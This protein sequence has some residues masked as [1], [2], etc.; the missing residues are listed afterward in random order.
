MNNKLKRYFLFLVLVIVLVILIVLALLPSKTLQPSTTEAP[1]ANINSNN[2]I[3]N[4]SQIVFILNTDIPS[5]PASMDLYLSQIES[6]LDEAARLAA[7]N[8]FSP[9]STTKWVSDDKNSF[10]NYS[11]TSHSINFVRYQNSNEQNADMSTSLDLAKEF[12]NA[13]GLSEKITIETETPLVLYDNGTH[14]SGDGPVNNVVVFKLEVLIDEY[15]IKY[16][17]SKLSAGEIWVKDNTYV[18][19]LSLYDRIDVTEKVNTVETLT[20]EE[21]RNQILAGQNLELISIQNAGTIDQPDSSIKQ[22]T[23]NTITIEYRY[24]ENT[25]LIH[26]YLR[27]KGQAVTNLSDNAY[28]E[29][30][31]PLEK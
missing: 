21:V 10:I 26:P 13:N 7:G 16:Q 3:T 23:I 1:P 2:Q 19:K 4:P 5:I 31:L 6:N 11:E 9:T 28:V 8:Q 15:P 17:G 25:K 12:L 14:L 20:S 24:S 30:L 18:S 22:V 27:I 29:Y